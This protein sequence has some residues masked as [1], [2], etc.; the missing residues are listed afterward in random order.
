[1]LF[2][3]R[4]TDSLTTSAAVNAK[5]TPDFTIL[6]QWLLSSPSLFSPRWM[7]LSALTLLWQ[8][9]EFLAAG[10]M[11]RWDCFHKRENTMLQR[12]SELSS[13]TNERTLI[14]CAGATRVDCEYLFF[15]VPGT[16]HSKTVLALTVRRAA[17]RAR[18][19]AN[20][21]VHDNRHCRH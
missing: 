2:T 15:A 19:E 7:L 8:L 16:S 21:A 9:Y 12:T 1:M 5:A 18:L 11:N 4:G 10:Q 6:D 13:F 17:A 3:Q 20:R 14:F